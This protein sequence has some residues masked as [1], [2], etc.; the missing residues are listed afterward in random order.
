MLSGDFSALCRTYSVNN[1]AATRAAHS[2]R[3]WTAAVCAKQIIE[4]DH[5]ASPTLLPYLPALTVPSQALPNDAPNYVARF[6]PVWHQR[7]DVRLDGDLTAGIRPWNRHGSVGDP[8]SRHRPNSRLQQRGRSGIQTLPLSARRPH[9]QCGHRERSPLGMDPVGAE[10]Q[11]AEHRL[12]PQSLFPSF[13][14]PT[15]AVSD[16]EHWQ[17]HDLWTD[18]A[19]LS[20]PRYDAGVRLRTCAGSTPSFGVDRPT[21]GMFAR[22]IKLTARWATAGHVLHGQWT[23]NGAGPAAACKQRLRRFPAGRGG[24]EQ[25]R[26][27]SDQRPDQVARLGVL[28]AGHLAGHGQADPELRATVQVPAVVAGPRR[29]SEFPGLRK[30]HAGAAAGLANGNRAASGFSAA[31][32][33][34]SVRDHSKRGLAPVV[35]RTGEEE[36]RS[37]RRVRVQTVFRQSHGVARRLGYLLRQPDRVDRSAENM[38]NP[39]WQLGATFTSQLPGNPAAP[40]LPT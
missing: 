35:L 18:G 24:L 33:R 8:W 29:S 9:V 39:P 5:V 34:V 31:T 19:D 23:G 30:Q 13:R 22:R 1:I 25:L 28:R 40:F 26:H 37:A 38:F 6:Q 4:H 15:T 16:D 32:R 3:P 2:V 14:S 27:R 20:I 36:L 10:Q 12:Q 11:R 7:L 17:L 21:A